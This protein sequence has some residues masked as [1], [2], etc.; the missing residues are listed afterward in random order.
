MSPDPVLIHEEALQRLDEYGS[1]E[2]TP[3]PTFDHLT[4]VAASLSD[5]A[6]AL[7]ISHDGQR[8]WCMSK[9]GSGVGE[10][11]DASALCAQVVSARAPIIVP[12]ARN[13]SRFSRDAQ[14]VGPPH[15]RFVAGFPLM[16]S[17]DGLVLGA[18]CLLDRRP[19]SLTPEQEH[20]LRGLAADASSLLEQ[21]R[22]EQRWREAQRARLITFER[23]FELSLELFCTFDR[24]F[25]F[26][27]LNPAWTAVLGYGLDELRARKFGDL[28]HP[29]DIEATRIVARYMLDES[30]SATDFVNRYRH[31]D[32][33]WVHLSWSG[34]AQNGVIFATARDLTAAR[35]REAV[36]RQRDQALAESA[37]QLQA[38]FDALDEGVLLQLADGQVAAT[39]LAARRIL[40]LSEAQINGR[41][42]ADFD[43]I[44]EDG[45]PFPA[46]ER[47][48]NVTL[49]TGQPQSDVMVGLPRPAGTL[50]LSLNCRPLFRPGE[51]DPYGVVTSLR[52]V[53][54]SKRAAERSELL[55]RQERLV[56]VGTLAAGVGHEINNPLS[57][58]LSNL[59]FATDELRG[60]FGAAP[61]GPLKTVLEVL[62]D[63]KRGAENVK[64]IVRGLR[65]LVRDDD[66]RAVTDIT[67]AVETAVNM[68]MH[69]LRT[70]AT[71][72]VDLPPLPQ[73]S[74]NES[75]LTQ[76]LVN[77]LVNAAQAFTTND[78]SVNQVVVRASAGADSV[79]L[80]VI[81]N[82][83][84]ILP[85][86]L[87]RIFDPFFT[88]KAV[89]QGRGLGLSVAHS[90]VMS[91]NGKLT[92]R[93][94]PGNGACFEINLPS[95]PTR[96]EGALVSSPAN[97][98]RR[99]RVLI[100]D[101]NVGVLKGQVRA[102]SK[103]H[104]VVG[105]H[106]P[107]EALR[108]FEHGERFDVVFCDMMMPYLAGPDLY[109]RALELDRELVRRFVF[110]TGGVTQ[111]GFDEFLDQVDNVRLEKPVSLQVFRDVVRRA[112][113]A[114]DR[115]PRSPLEP[116]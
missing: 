88:T 89:G 13:D 102:L 12:D 42:P 14:V 107:R 32:G 59:E 10:D 23:F 83:P 99:G 63:A 58:V 22:G 71:V 104:D 98:A 1:L 77:L 67:L 81:D 78:P 46:S 26:L 54:E 100:I 65:S 17:D 56:T 101:D 41:K 27:E 31:K 60:L 72:S 39:N 111:A 52:D 9:Y 36:L 90:I 103:H 96:H 80:A 110:I 37:A 11:A 20:D 87:P 82:G 66:P 116:G 94:T 33:H 93:S 43:V 35:E 19:R 62:A 21:R 29:D 38:V 7:I 91:L 34:R 2:A 76:V 113:D 50:W 3:T 6:L 105:E 115:E 24:S 109:E 112:L 70:K 114:G 45:S 53:T 40:G 55:A 4:G 75:R 5:A 57:Y 18:L 68:S 15:W 106:D 97:A 49:R 61:T 74:T 8:Q 73:V 92:C 85:D 51:P 30:S 108:R 64:R 95:V 79:T 84:G 48:T 16:A 69:E 28:L 86:V 47:P 25:H 44:R